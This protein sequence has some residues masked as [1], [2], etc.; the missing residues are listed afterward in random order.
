MARPKVLLTNAIDPA[1]FR[2]LEKETDVE[3]APDVQPATLKRL[4]ATADALIVRAQ[5][6]DDIFGH[7][8]MLHCAVRHG[9]GLDMIPV[10]AATA[11]GIAVA[12]VPGVNAEA[13]AEYC[14]SGMLLMLRRMHLIDRDLRAKDWGSARKLADDSR[15]LLGRTLGVV[16]VGAVGGRIAEICHQAFRMPVLGHQRR[17]DALPSFVKG[18]DLDTLFAESDFVVLACPLTAATRNL[19]SR[20]RIAKMRKGTYL[21]NVSRG[22]VVDED[23]LVEALRERRIGGAVLDVYR[24]QPIARDHPLLKMDNVVLSPHAAG[25][26]GEAMQKMSE[27]AARDVLRVLAGEKPVNFAN[28]EVWDAYTKRRKGMGL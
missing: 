6:P 17:L 5:L 1:G 7:A 24:E 10:E 28:P 19:A 2:I 21:I 13:V 12:Y 14:L 15:E 25:I 22:P 3:V 27:S 26:T 11:Q 9:A 20:E 4:V 16:G 8:P 18:V 23:A